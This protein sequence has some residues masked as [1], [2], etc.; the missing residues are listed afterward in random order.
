MRFWLLSPVFRLLVRYGVNYY[1]VMRNP[2]QTLFYMMNSHHFDPFRDTLNKLP[3]S[4]LVKF[5]TRERK[6]I[7][8]DFSRS[9]VQLQKEELSILNFCRFIEQVVAGQDVSPCTVPSAH[10]RFYRQV[11]EKLVA[12]HEL[13]ADAQKQFDTAFSSGKLRHDPE[14]R[15]TNAKG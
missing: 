12:A 1:L 14:G 6:M 3:P 2:G 13:P 10:A 8:D 5:I 9:G 11:V 7:E 4:V 15:L